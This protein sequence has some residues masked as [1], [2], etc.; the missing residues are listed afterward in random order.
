MWGEEGRS[1][2]SPRAW[3]RRALQPAGCPTPKTALQFQVDPS[4][5]PQSSPRINPQSNPVVC[6]IPGS[7]LG[8]KVHYSSIG[9]CTDTTFS[10]LLHTCSTTYDSTPHQRRSRHGNNKYGQHTGNKNSSRLSRLPA[11]LVR[12]VGPAGCVGSV[13]IPRNHS[14][15]MPP[16]A[17]QSLF[18]S[19]CI[20]IVRSQE[21]ALHAPTVYL[22]P[23]G[24][25]AQDCLRLPG[26]A[27]ASRGRPGS[28]C[29]RE[30]GGE[31]SSNP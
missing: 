24:K 12:T 19:Q 16:K 4:Q 29:R 2:G 23:P 7:D 3:Q 21:W 18:V 15:N 6:K 8:L 11:R 14:S 5:S 13:A 17:S 1:V 10:K 20:H 22:T 30:W 28:A 26:T 9:P 27:G 31:I 25:T